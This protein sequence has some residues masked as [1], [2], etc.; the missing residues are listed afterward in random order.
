MK[1]AVQPESALERLALLTKQVPIPVVH[2]L[3]G[4]LLARTVMAAT[5]LGTFEAVQGTGRT[6]VEVARVCN[7]DPYATRRL[8]D[9]LV[10]AGYLAQRGPVYRLTWIS[11]KWLLRDSPTSLRDVI[12][13]ESLEWD[14]LSRLDTFLRTGQPLD[15]HATMRRA[16]WAHYQRAMRAIAGLVAAEVARRLSVPPHARA[17]LDI[18][19]A[20]GYYAVALCRRHAG[21][22]A[23][24][25]DRPE[26]I[27]HAAPLLAREGV[28]ERV[29]HQTG[30]ARVDDL[31]RAAYDLV[32]MAQLVHHFDDTT[33]RGLVRRAARALR[34]GGLLAIL[35]PIRD[36]TRSERGQLVGLLDLYFAF[37]SRAGTRSLD[38][39]AGWQREA[40]MVARRPLHLRTLPGFAV[41]AAT[42]ILPEIEGE[43]SG[44]GGNPDGSR[45]RHAARPWDPPHEHDHG[46]SPA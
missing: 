30:D 43:R 35:E 28:G 8:L 9:A 5:R 23:T 34:P 21:L 31:G 29:V 20:H 27:E 13:Y 46:S 38:E 37:T 33:N 4:A 22:R 45:S 16:E 42:K 44:A 25:L 2:A 12:L 11:R 19:G 17:M 1:L 41:Q 39:L 7:T 3:G 24:V 40:G 18:G 15:V 10:S 32:L 6:A 36:P 14:W 26:A